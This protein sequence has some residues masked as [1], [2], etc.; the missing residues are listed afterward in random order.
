MKTKKKKNVKTI[1]VMKTNAMV[2]PL[3]V[4][5]PS[6]ANPYYSPFLTIMAKGIR[7]ASEAVKLGCKT[8]NLVLDSCKV[9][10]MLI[11][12]ILKT[13]NPLQYDLKGIGRN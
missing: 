6:S 9:V 11:C 5:S 10:G 7:L 1:S 3:N 12:Y 13:I 4:S 2:S 8:V